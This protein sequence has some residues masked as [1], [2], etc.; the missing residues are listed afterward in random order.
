MPT[1]IPMPSLGR[2][3]LR[4]RVLFAAI[5][6]FALAIAFP[7]SARAHAQLDTSDPVANAILP[8]APTQVVMGFT[9]RLEHSRTNARLFGQDGQEV[10]GAASRPGDGPRELILDLPPGLRNGTYSVVWQT[11]SIDDGHPAQ[12]YFAFTIGTE[13][14]V[15]VVVPPATTT[16]N[17]APEWLRTASRW[18]ALL[19]LALATA[20]WPVWLLVLRP[21]IAPAWRRGPEL[22]RRARGY[23]DAV[24]VFTLLGN[25]FAIGVQAADLPSG[26]FFENLRTT[27]LDTR[28]GE[29]WI[30]R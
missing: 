6:I 15:V 25:L 3:A 22:V 29:L 4:H 11:L 20:V 28:Y 13:A 12:G 14:D 7:G 19:G 30:I 9:E 1:P 21:G 8:A 2:S 24:I 10:T 18:A 5:I 16:T 23:A 17:G 26:G 27:L